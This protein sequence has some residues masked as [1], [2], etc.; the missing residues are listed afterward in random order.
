MVEMLLKRG[1]DAD[2]QRKDSEETI[3]HFMLKGYHE[4]K[5][6]TIRI[7]LLLLRHKANFLLS[8]REGKNVFESALEVGL[9]LSECAGLYQKHQSS[10]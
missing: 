1:A 5:E 8:T 10:A 2:L 4:N 3:A 9:D 7:L 6:P